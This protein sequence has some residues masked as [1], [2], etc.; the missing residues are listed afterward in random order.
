MGNRGKDLWDGRNKEGGWVPKN[1][2]MG[3]LGQM[4]RETDG[5]ALK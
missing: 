2:E 3:S 4:I 1:E 5:K